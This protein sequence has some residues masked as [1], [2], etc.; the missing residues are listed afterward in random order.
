MEKQT[1]RQILST[2]DIAG[3]LKENGVLPTQ[4][5][6]RIANPAAPDDRQGVV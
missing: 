3:V 2:H 6:W 5:E 1:V 4:R